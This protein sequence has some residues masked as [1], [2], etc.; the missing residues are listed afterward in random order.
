MKNKRGQVTLFIIVA[1]LIII[2][3]AIIYFLFPGIGTNIKQDTENPEVYLQQCLQEE[4]ESKIK[5]ITS[6]G[7]SLKP[8][9]YIMYEGDKI[10]YYCYTEEY[11]K[12][13]VVQ[14]PLIKHH[15]EKGILN[16]IDEKSKTCFDEM[17]NSFESKGYEVELDRKGKSVNIMPGR[18]I[19]NFNHSLALTKEDTKNYDKFSISVNNKLYEMVFIAMS[20]ID[21]ETSYGDAETTV[22]M[23]YYRDIKVEK[24][25]QSDGSTIY[26]LTDR[27]KGTKFQFA[28]RSIPWPPGYA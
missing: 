22:Y 26:I 18:T 7:G 9:H 16:A 8:E 27:D 2:I 6:H 20:I 1:I 4:F 28:S 12:T 13:C 10:E 3:G 25:K 5:N 17:V 15:V 24:K 23:D 14:R 11:Y 21:W 19:L